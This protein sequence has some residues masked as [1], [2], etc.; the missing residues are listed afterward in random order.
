A[1]LPHDRTREERMRGHGDNPLLHIPLAWVP[2]VLATLL[3]GLQL[4]FWEEATAQ[5][6]EMLDLLVF[7]TCIRCLLEYRLELRES[8]LWRFALLMGLGMAGNWAMIGFAPFFLF[9]IC[10]IR[11][12]AILNAGFLLRLAGWFALGLLAYLVMPLVSQSQAGMDLSFGQVLQQT[13]GGQK[14]YLLGLPRSR[15]LL[16]ALVML[17]PLAMAGIRWAG[18]T[19]TKLESMLSNGAVGLFRIAFLAA[20]V[21]MAFD[22]AFSLRHLIRLDPQQAELPVLTFSFAAALAAGYFSGYFLLLGSVRPANSWERGPAG[23]QTIVKLGAGLMLLLLVGV[24]A[25]LAVRNWPVIHAQNGAALGQFAARFTSALPAGPAL[26]VTD[27][28]LLHSLIGAQFRRADAGS[29]RLLFNTELAPIP[30]YRRQL[31][32]EH[33]TKWPG[34]IAFANA[35]EGV[36]STF[37]R[38]LE[39][40]ATNGTA[41]SLNPS[42]NFLTEQWQLRAAG[43]ILRFAHYIPG[44]VEAPPLTAEEAA[45]VTEFWEKLRPD[46]DELTV[47]IKLGALNPILAGELW[48]RAANDDGVA[49]QRS[50]RLEAAAPLFTLALKLNPDNLASTVNSKVNVAL[51]AHQPI[52]DEARKPLLGKSLGAVV[53]G[54]GQ[55]DEPVALLSLGRHYSSAETPLLRAAAVSFLRARQLDPSNEEAAMAYIS[56]LLNAGEPQM[57][58][59]AIADLRAGGSLSTAEQ[60]GL[61]RFE[62]GANLML[63]KADNSE[64]ELLK[65]RD[66][67]PKET[68]AYDLLSQLYLQQARYD[69]ALQQLDKWE[70]LQPDDLNIPQ[71]RVV[72][73]MSRGQFDRAVPLL[74]K[75][76]RLKSDNEVA[77]ANRAISLL[78]LNRLDDALRDYELLARSHP[79][80]YIFQYGL[81]EIADRKKDKTGA[82]LHFRS[83]LELAPKNTSEFTNVLGRVNQ[84]DG[85]K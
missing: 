78:Q 56:A 76:I 57:G 35:K 11:G 67:L 40:S 46:L 36:A 34:L 19:G 23:G 1:L 65:A 8:W 16:L 45:K 20:A 29:D 47:G 52:T 53:A 17:L 64:P 14:N 74:D 22:P 51:R 85:G 58:L 49:L 69:E 63:N 10:W 2:P 37:V 77:R 31:A 4:T 48:S 28:S 71:R 12:L 83:Y 44:Q 75:I 30:G 18:A 81:G 50:G 54:L 27:D 9:A 82:L 72:A 15:F 21:Y 43:G 41:F 73:F 68:V 6:G 42:V 32:R 26:V 66:A 84:L 25:G 5:T 55:L 38:L 61:L 13:L 59:K 24:P 3:L 33:G 7:A 60:V 79:D 80:Q 62:F 70:Q 39:Q